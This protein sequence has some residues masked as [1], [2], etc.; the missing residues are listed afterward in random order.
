MPE[1]LQIMFRE[2]AAI[3]GVIASQLRRTGRS[4]YM[5]VG[6]LCW[7]VGSAF[8]GTRFRMA[9]VFRLY[10]CCAFNSSRR[11]CSTGSV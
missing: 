6:L 1:S 3:V 8:P 11:A 10:L 5:P 2:A 7:W 9:R 4:A